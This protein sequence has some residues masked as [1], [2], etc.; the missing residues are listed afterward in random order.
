[1]KKIITLTVT[2]VFV[3]SS[4]SCQTTYDAYGYPRQ[5]VDPVMAVAGV[6]AAG[7]IGYALAS[8]NNNT[9]HRSNQNHY[10]SNQNHH[11]GHRYQ[12]TYTQ[13]RHYGSYRNYNHYDPYC[14]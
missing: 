7:V 4:V 6:A 3:I 11:Y 10:S 1:M 5:S 14:Y 2:A 9:R 8:D 13:T 12:T